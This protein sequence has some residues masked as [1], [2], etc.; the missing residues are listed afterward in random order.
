MAN[1]VE[2]IV[3]NFL[4]S[5]RTPLSTLVF[6]LNA[7]ITKPAI[8]VAPIVITSVLNIR[9]YSEFVK[10]PTSFTDSQVSDLFDLMFWL[11][12]LFPLATGVIEALVLL[13][14]RM[15][16]PPQKPAP[17]SSTVVKIAPKSDVAAT[18]V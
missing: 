7:L 10:S 4:R 3:I 15:K 17:N 8:S 6:T 14:Y 18:F 9:R 16:F 5:Y 13:P 1:E 11:V 12:C 2:I